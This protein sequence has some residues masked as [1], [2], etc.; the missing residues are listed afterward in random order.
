VL[1]FARQAEPERGVT[2]PCDL[3][4]RMEGS[5]WLC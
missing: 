3:S 5:C 4:G 1:G 2:H